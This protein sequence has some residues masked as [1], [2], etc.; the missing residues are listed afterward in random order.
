MFQHIKKLRAPGGGG[1]YGKPLSFWGK[2]KGGRK[3]RKGKNLKIGGRGKI[4]E[5]LS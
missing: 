3:N 1:V 5:N 4:N 2:L